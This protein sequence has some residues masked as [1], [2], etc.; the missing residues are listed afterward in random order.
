MENTTSFFNKTYNEKIQ[1]NDFNTDLNILLMVVE[2]MS[3]S[4][5]VKVIYWIKK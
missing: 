3:L 1:I 4:K 2:I 5:E